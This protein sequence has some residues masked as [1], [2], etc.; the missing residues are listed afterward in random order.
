MPIVIFLIGL[1][2]LLYGCYLIAPAAA[3]I[4]GGILFMAIAVNVERGNP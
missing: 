1:V 4:V 3:L 2:G